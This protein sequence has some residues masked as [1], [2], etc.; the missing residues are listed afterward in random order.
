[1]TKP[2]VTVVIPTFN[3]AD[4]I[5]IAINSALSQTEKCNVIV[6]DHGSSDHTQEV[7]GKFGAQVEYIRLSDDLGPI[8][9]WVDGVMRT[10]TEFVKILF[11]DDV[12]DPD[13]VAKALPMMGSKVGFV[14]TNARLVNLDS[15]EVIT[16][17]LFGSFN[18]TGLF[19]SSGIKGARISRQMIS[20]SALLLRRRDVVDG[21]YLGSLPFSQHEHH[22]AG[23]DHYVKLLVMLRYKYFGLINQSLVTFGAHEGSITV[24][25]SQDNERQQN[26]ESVYDEVWIFYQQLRFLS[27]VAIP[28]KLLNRIVRKLE[29]LVF[30]LRGRQ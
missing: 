4:R 22:G 30:R 14:A 29:S 18:K 8:F 12:L 27:F 11:D 19:K 20:P 16:D 24:K 10:Q 15:G 23:P 17:S 7:V 26:L 9:S 28:F 6:V 25:A 13:F 2:Q 1:L 5:S 21:L 3:R